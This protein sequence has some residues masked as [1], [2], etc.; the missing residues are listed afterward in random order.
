MKKLISL[1]L[2]LVMVFALATVAFA[3]EG[4]DPTYGGKLGQEIKIEKKYEVV[5][6]TAPAETFEFKFTAVSYK[7]ADDA[8]HGPEGMP[9]IPNIPV[10]FAATS[11][12]ATATGTA[13][14]DPTAYALGTYT[15]KVEEVVPAS[16]TAGITYHK[17]FESNEL[18]LV[19][20]ILRDTDGN[21]YV[22]A[23][24]YGSASSTKAGEV[25]NEYNSGSLSVTKMIDGN[26]A[27]M[28]EIFPFT[29]TFTVP[30]GT[31]GKSSIGVKVN[32][33]AADPLSFVNGVATWNGELGHEK[34]VSFTNIPAGCHYTVEETD[35][36][37]YHAETVYSD[38]DQLIS[39]NDT[40]T[41]VVTN[42]RKT[43]V[44]T[45]I[46]LDSMPY[47]LLM[48]VAVFGMAMLTKKRSYEN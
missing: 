45:G 44:D 13:A 6:G 7:D 11:E 16:P 46:V 40:D 25:V 18:T 2:A 23:L 36:K 15:Y 19:L 9:S 39:A 30:E 34:N 24:H 41:V 12:T 26:M 32:G 3:A 5:N 21:N 42:T 29:I 47:V 31:T 48:V 8:D 22:A 33:E 35:S 27:E 4:E 10:E 38:D 28:D 14:I 43:T 20:T 37:G 17:N 1:L